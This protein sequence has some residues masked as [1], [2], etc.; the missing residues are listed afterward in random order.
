MRSILPI[1]LLS[2]SLAVPAARG[3]DFDPGILRNGDLIFQTSRSGQSRAIQLATRSPWSHC[4]IVYIKG[5]KPYV[6]EAS[7]EV[8]LSPFRRFVRKG[9]GRR[10]EIRRLLSADSLLTAPN[11]R[12]LK[13]EGRRF[14]GR[15]YDSFFGWSGDR[16]Y[17]SELVYKMYLNA[18]GIRIGEIRKLEDF[19]LSH[20][21]VRSLMAQRYGEAVPYGEPVIAPSDMHRDPKLFTVYSNFPRD[22]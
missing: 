12:R 4:G 3:G 21:A 16:I 13:A 18:L 7:T 17:C 22:P 1:L 20:P 11:L 15:P 10:F 6:F 8:K 14:D 9:E 19:D 2:V 5:G